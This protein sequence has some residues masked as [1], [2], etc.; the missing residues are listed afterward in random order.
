MKPVIKEAKL[1][2]KTTTSK[3]ANKKLLK[4][5]DGVAKTVTFEVIWVNNLNIFN[6]GA[7]DIYTSWDSVTEKLEKP[8]TVG[9]RSSKIV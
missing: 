1:N 9:S 4:S 6:R 5:D 8:K 7:A 3:L 2:T